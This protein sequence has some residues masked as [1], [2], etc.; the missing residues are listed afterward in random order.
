MSGRA[1]C[2]NEW[3]ALVWAQTA[4]QTSVKHYV[5]Q[6]PQ[7]YPKLGCYGKVV[8][9]RSMSNPGLANGLSLHLLIYR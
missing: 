9:E 8:S 6:R 3:V 1:V 2:K 7:N 4:L 5:L